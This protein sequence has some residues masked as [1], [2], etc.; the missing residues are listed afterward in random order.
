MLLLTDTGICLLPAMD[1]QGE[2][3]GDFV[4]D[5]IINFPLAE[6]LLSKPDEARRLFCTRWK[7]KR[8]R[9]SLS[10]ILQKSAFSQISP[11]G[12]VQVVSV[13]LVN[14]QTLIEACLT[15]TGLLKIIT[16]SARRTLRH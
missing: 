5:G 3:D 11:A 2:A 12:F 6:G 4:R 14:S 9:P 8:M 10:G 15:G 7:K 13:C 16:R 1:D